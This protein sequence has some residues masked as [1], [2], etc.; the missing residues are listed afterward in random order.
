[1]D[2]RNGGGDVGSTNGIVIAPSQALSHMRSQLH[3]SRCT[4]SEIDAS[5]FVWP[6]RNV[7]SIAH[8]GMCGRSRNRDDSIVASLRRQK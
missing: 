2:C 1:M 4:S 7:H 3:A 8:Q 5:S 6:L